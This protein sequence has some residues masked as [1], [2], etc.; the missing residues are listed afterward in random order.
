MKLCFKSLRKPVWWKD[1]NGTGALPLNPAGENDFLRTPRSGLRARAVRMRMK[2]FVFRYGRLQWA[3]GSP[4]RGGSCSAGGRASACLRWPTSSPAF[5]GTDVSKERISRCFGAGERRSVVGSRRD[6]SG[7]ENGETKA[8]EII[9]PVAFSA[10]LSF[11]PFTQRG[12][13][14]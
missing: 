6:A 5:A 2:S 13:R 1:R 12:G 11:P 7:T 3:G 10:V 9:S 14:G 4:F 8:G